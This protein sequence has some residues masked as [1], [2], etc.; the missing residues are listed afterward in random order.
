MSELVDHFLASAD[1]REKGLALSRL[2]TELI[3]ERN[4]FIPDEAWDAVQKAFMLP[5]PEVLLFKTEGGV[6]V[7]EKPQ[8]L[9]TYRFDQDFLGWHIPGGRWSD[10]K[11]T[12][13]EAC[14]KVAQR[15]LGLPVKLHHPLLFE[16]WD[17]HPYGN[18]ISL[19]CICST[20]VS[21]IET[22]TMKFFDHVPTPIV[23]PHHADFIE[24]GFQYIRNAPHPRTNL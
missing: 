17:D 24:A 5:Y 15:E 7:N 3:G 8:A 21:V 1:S 6:W 4:G 12:L 22:P 14:Q 20:P 23:S 2:V 19:V 11:L 13:E 10:P 9:L 16:K 18:P